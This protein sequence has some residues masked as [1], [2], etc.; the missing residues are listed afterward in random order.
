MRSQLRHAAFCGIR[1]T[2]LV[3]LTPT[4]RLPN[5]PERTRESI[6]PGALVEIS[7]TSPCKGGWF[8]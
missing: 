2:Y 1:I 6:Q 3:S 8:G 4:P 7:E 5:S